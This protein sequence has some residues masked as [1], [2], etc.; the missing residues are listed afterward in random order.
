MI[1]NRDGF[2]IGNGQSDFTRD[3][4][5]YDFKHNDEE[6]SLIDVPGIEGNEEE[7]ID[8]IQKALIKSH[9]IFYIKK[10]PTPPQKGDKNK[11]GI[12]EKIK[13]Q[14]NDQAEIYAIY[15]KPINSARTLENELIDKQTREGLNELDSKM[16]EYLGEFYK[17]HK[18]LSAQLAFYALAN[19][20]LIKIQIL[21]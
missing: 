5:S 14:L 1:E 4:T 12:I 2:I 13:E 20:L 11:K 18:V 17:G 16:N 15:N 9:V 3:I 6:F 19:N 21:H 8:K 10:E 7:V